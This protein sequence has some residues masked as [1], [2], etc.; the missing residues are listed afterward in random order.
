M[1]DPK[2]WGTGYRY[3]LE[4]FHSLC[5]NFPSPQSFPNALVSELCPFL[6]T[7]YWC[8]SNASPDP[9]NYEQSK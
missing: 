1:G 7:P 4:S 8:L 6:L 3:I 5:L 9:E 2:E